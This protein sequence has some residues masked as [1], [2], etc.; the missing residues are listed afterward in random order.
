MVLITFLGLAG[1]ALD[2]AFVSSAQV[3]LKN[4]LRTQTLALLSVLEVDMDRN[5]VMPKQLPEAR[6]MSP[7]SRLNA[8]I[9][10]RDGSIAW[11][12]PSSLGVSFDDLVIAKTK[13]ED[14]SQLGS[15][16]S[17]P[18]RY[19][20]PVSWENEQGVE[21]EF[22]LIVTE[23]SNHFSEFVNEHRKKIILWLGLAGI[24]LLFMQMLTLHWS[25]LPLARVSQEIDQIERAR[26][27]QIVGTYPEEIAQLSQRINL[28]VSKERKNLERYR[29]TLGDL[30][31]S[32]KTP[33]A[34]IRGLIENRGE[35]AD[36]EL[37][38]YVDTMTNIVEYQ[39]EKAASSRV[40]IVQSWIDVAEVVTK[41]L[42]AMEKVHG[43]KTI[44][45]VINILPQLKFYGDKSDLYELL[46][47]VIDNAYKWSADRVQIQARSISP[48]TGLIQGVEILV[49][50]DGPGV[51]DAMR[52]V[53]F[54]RGM[55]ADQ[56][57]E[58]QGIGLAVSREIV[59]GYNGQLT[60][61]DSDLGGAKIRIQ[62][63][64]SV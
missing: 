49:E 4:Q 29:N 43:G 58:G 61:G 20:F 22:S 57:V 59:D 1:V 5:I 19:S 55:R 44:S 62:L 21:Y 54:R 27:N 51:N 63:R 39:L 46:G 15:I 6:L 53:V 14:F 8:V 42:E 28:F 47:N 16:L 33:L 56:R 50:D 11:Q 48:E 64:P 10:D 7:D 3:S 36:K 12:S 35:K 38:Q 60:I 32:L 34:V 2:R 18:Y 31:H 26:Q 37:S 9:L 30:A 13:G 41:I 40:S 45:T 52:D 25:L 17:S 23:S 24:F